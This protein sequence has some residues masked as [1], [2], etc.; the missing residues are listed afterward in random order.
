ML[1]AFVD[2]LLGQPPEIVIPTLLILAALENVFP[3]VPADVAT[4]LGAFWAERT[5]RSPWLIGLAC[6]LSNQLSATWVYLWARRNGEAVLSHPWFAALMPDDLQ[7][8]IR[9]SVEKNG[10]WGIFV[11]RFF[12]GVRAAVLPFAAIHGLSPMRALVPAALASLAWYAFLTAAGAS[13]GLAYDQVRDVVTRAT[14]TLGV[15]GA[16]VVAVAFFLLWRRSHA[17]RRPQ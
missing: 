9:A 6:F 14:T 2:W 12:P 1:N 5:G 10:A 13:L 17:R 8:K 4:A 7:P 16:V 3:P 11:S 15:I